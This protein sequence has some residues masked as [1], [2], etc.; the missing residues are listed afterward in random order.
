MTHDTALRDDQMHRLVQHAMVSVTASDELV[1]GGVRRGRR[2]VR[3]RRVVR[4]VGVGAAA[5]LATAAV[6]AAPSLLGGH[7]DQRSPVA[8]TPTDSAPS[9]AARPTS[10]SAPQPTPTGLPPHLQR[11]QDLLLD[12]L[13]ESIPDPG[14]I[15]RVDYDPDGRGLGEIVEV[16]AT[17]DSAIVGRQ[18]ARCE[19]VVA[20]P[21]PDDCVDTGAGWIFTGP[22]LPDVSGGSPA[23]AGVQATYIL[24]DGRS[25]NLTAYNAT[26]ASLGGEPTRTDPVLDADDMIELLTRTEWFDRAP[27]R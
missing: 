10:G 27:A 22:S 23:L 3:R 9:A 15:A 16:V 8:G 12:A 21:A 24:R 18:D 26:R 20:S 2:A 1:A 6:V 13:P 25:V 19:R 4:T 14:Y 5:A 17:D 7:D 11:A